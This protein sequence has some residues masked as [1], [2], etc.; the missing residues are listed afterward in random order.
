MKNDVLGVG[1]D[2]D[3]EV[4]FV[5]RTFISSSRW[6]PMP[7]GRREVILWLRLNGEKILGRLEDTGECRS[8]T[9]SST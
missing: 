8:K 3:L 9:Y 4:F 5:T 6:F 2:D 7:D 1:E